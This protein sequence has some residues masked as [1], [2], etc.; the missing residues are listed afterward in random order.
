MFKN[1]H[2]QFKRNFSFATILL[3]LFITKL[4]ERPMSRYLWQNQQDLPSRG[5]TCGY[6]NHPLASAKGWVGKG[7]QN[8]NLNAFVFICH[9]CTGPTFIDHNGNQWPGVVFGNI[10]ND[11]PEKTVSDLYD[12]ARRATVAGAYTAAVLCCRKLLM[13]I[14]VAKGAKAGQSFASY[15]DYLSDNH[16]ISPDAKDWVD[17]IRDK[18]N[19]ANHEI[20]IVSGE[21][22]KD[23]LAF[24]EMLLKTIFEFP[25]VIRKK[26]AKPK[27]P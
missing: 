13:H 27:T 25:A 12:E 14:A 26:L 8:V 22:A 19:E 3:Y 20:V 9:H 2:V 24:C 5:Y 7:E 6:C 15:V 21:D 17:H 16:Y 11:I 23:L 4:A 10:V 18:G 1:K